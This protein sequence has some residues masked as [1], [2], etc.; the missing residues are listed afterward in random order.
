LKKPYLKLY[1]KVD[2]FKVYLVDGSY[3][4]S[5]LN[6]QFT[7]F[8]QHYRFPK[9][10]PLKEFWLDDEYSNPKEYKFFI[11]HLLEEWKVMNRGVSYDKAIVE[12]DA[13]E[14]RERDLE[15]SG[16]FK[17]AKLGKI[18]DV[19]VW[20]VDG[21][22]VRDD[23]FIDFTEGGHDLVYDFIPPN[24]IWLDNAVK[25]EERPYILAHEFDERKKMAETGEAYKHAHNQASYLELNL[26][27][28]KPNMGRLVHRKGRHKIN[29]PI[30]TML[31]K[32]K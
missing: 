10:I 29:K 4:R 32:I 2:G 14:Q 28:T 13:E 23:D 11:D 15:E 8:A 22:K 6:D 24:E 30:M 27:H 16:R 26:R 21:R 25:P 20:L 3:I 1:D 31:S 5:H 18:G 7:N 17:I 12:A 19:A 9:M